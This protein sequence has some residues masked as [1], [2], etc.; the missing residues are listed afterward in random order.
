MTNVNI[1]VDEQPFPT[2]IT[3]YMANK[4]DNVHTLQNIIIYDISISK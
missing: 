2:I 3:Q 1:T 4:P